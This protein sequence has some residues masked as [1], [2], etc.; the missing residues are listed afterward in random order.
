[1]A[2]SL[3]RIL[4]RRGTDVALVRVVGHITDERAL[5]KNG[6]LHGAGVPLR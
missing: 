6:L 5:K 2:I 3:V 1:M 4:I